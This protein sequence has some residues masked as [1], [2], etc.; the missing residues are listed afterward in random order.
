M[1]YVTILT[2]PSAPTAT[3]PQARC[4]VASTVANLV[5]TGTNIKWYDAPTGGSQLPTNTLL[6]NN[7]IYY[8]SQTDINTC[9]SSARRGV[10]AKTRPTVALDSIEGTT[11]LCIGASASYSINYDPT[12]QYSWSKN[13]GS[14][15]STNVI[16]GKSVYSVTWDVKPVIG[17]AYVKVSVANGSYCTITSEEYRVD[18][19]DLP[20]SQNV[21]GTPQYYCHND[22]GATISLSGSQVGHKYI[23]KRVSDG[24]SVNGLGEPGTGSPLNINN[25]PVQNHTNTGV[26]S[27][28]YYVVGVS[29]VGSCEFTMSGTVTLTKYALVDPGTIGTSQAICYNTVPNALTSETLPNGGDGTFSYQ[30]QSSTNNIDWSDIDGATLTTYAPSNL[31]TTTYFRRGTY[32]SC[33]SIYY[34]SAVTITVNPQIITSPTHTNVTCFGASD[35][36][37]TLNPS[38]GT[39]GYTYVWTKDGVPGFNETTE[40][41]TNLGFGIYSVVVTDDENCTVTNSVT[42]EQPSQLTAVV[43]SSDVTCKD[44]NNGI[45]NFTEAFGGYGRPQYSIDGGSTWTPL[46]TVADTSLTGLTPGSYVI[47]MRDATYPACVVSIPPIR[48]IAEPEFALSATLDFTPHINCYAATTGTI[49]ITNPIG[50]WGHYEYTINGGTN[51][52]SSGNFTNIGAGEYNVQMRDSAHTD[53]VHILNAAVVITQ[54]AVI[55]ATITNTP[56]ICYNGNTGT[57]TF[58]NPI[59]GAGTFDFNIGSGWTSEQTAPYTFTGLISGTYPVSIRDAAAPSCVISLGNIIITQPTLLTASISGTNVLCYNGTTGAAD[60]TVAGGTAGYT[61]AWT[62]NST[63]IGPTTQ[64]L[65]SLNIG[66]YAVTVTDANL[67]TATASVVITQNTQIILSTSKVDVSCN[68]GSNGSIDL[69]V[70]GGTGGYTYLWDDFDE[71]TTQDLSGLSAGTYI[72]VVSDDSF[73]TATTSVVITEPTVL[74]ATYEQTSPTCFD[75]NDGEIDVNPAGG[76]APY[77]YLWTTG[78]TTEIRTGLTPGI[79]EVTVTDFKGCTVTISPEVLN[80]APWIPEI[81]SE[82]IPNIAC[83]NSLVQYSAS[84]GEDGSTFE[85]IVEG[86]VITAGQNTDMVT[87]QWG[88]T[89]GTLTVKET[90]LAGCFNTSVP[91]MVTI[92]LLPTPSITGSTVVMENATGVTYTTDFDSDNLYTWNVTGGIIATGLGTNEITVNWGLGGTGMVTVTETNQY[93]CSGTQTI[94][95]TIIPVGYTV[96]GYVVYD[97]NFETPLNGVTVNLLDETNQ[98]IATTTSAPNY[99]ANG[100]LGYYEFNNVIVGNYTLNAS[101]NGTFGGNNATDALIVQLNTVGSFPLGFLRTMAADVNASGSIS[102]ADALR[103]KLRTVGSTNFYPAGDWKFDSPNVS[104]VDDE[105]S[106]DIYGL[107]VGDVNGSFVPTTGAKTAETFIPTIADNTISVQKGQSFNY[108]IKS[109]GIASLGAMTLV[110][111]YNENQFEIENI[112]SQLEDLTYE[113]KNGKVTLAWFNTNGVS[114]IE[115]LV[116]L[117]LKAKQSFDS[118]TEVFTVSN[119][120]EFADN[121]ATVLNNVN[122]KLSKVITKEITVDNYPNPFNN[123]TT[124]IYTIPEKSTVKITLSNIVGQTIATITEDVKAAGTHNVVLNANTYNLKN[125]IYFY[126]IEVNGINTSYVRT[127]KLVLEK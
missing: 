14:N 112:T 17:S 54:P 18:I 35:G 63:P 85:W 15:P 3:S 43:T 48:V 60:L 5:A 8:A 66:T 12:Y 81:Y 96:S 6:V 39:P 92:S 56:V 16:A 104:V 89:N 120:T 80:I 91:Y 70:T 46:V 72:V 119:S 88:S 64:D 1:P 101:Y 76:T 122:L 109:D 84:S 52:Q 13:G 55:S 68:G 33:D 103:I 110:M 47:Q 118:E 113:V 100:E 42:V 125:G 108:N 22:A 61:Y 37:I 106:L 111:N 51:W 27:T 75:G 58:S 53:C 59:G 45:I 93:G 86:G 21:N 114:N 82:G 102:G 19:R 67:C 83:E 97:N 98:I 73:C 123:A 7:T 30:W 65:T 26:E 25:I 87:I 9:E 95:V 29:D 126:T 32:N 10:T 94:N 20:T 50:G 127:N 116:S 31:D 4:E 41:L 24:A 117:Q 115:N 44:A 28:E 40:D 2:L 124:I 77:T 49:T 36:T 34:T 38:G 57:I 62:R 99:E 74:T 71:S 79:Y 78:E 90:R 23:V 69:S 121:N 105:V 11:L 107:C